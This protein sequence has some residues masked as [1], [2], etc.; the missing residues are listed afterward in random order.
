MA[1]TPPEP[2][3]PIPPATTLSYEQSAAL[4]NNSIFR[5]RVKVACLKF[6]NSIL[7]EATSVTGHTSRVKWATATFGYPDQAA[8]Q[9]QPPTVMDAAVQDAGSDI[10]D[11]A[12]QAS[13][14]VT[15]LKML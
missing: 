13:V 14:E 1:P 12:L 15:V 6:A 10:T 2:I 3:V 7:D 8:Q 9:A 4:M 5:G 11:D